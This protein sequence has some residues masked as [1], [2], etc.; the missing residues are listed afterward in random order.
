MSEEEEDE[1]WGEDEEE[2]E[3]EMREKMIKNKWRKKK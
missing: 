2:V 3:G 1:R